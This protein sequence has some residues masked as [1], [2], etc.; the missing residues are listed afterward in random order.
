ML[1]LALTTL[2]LSLLTLLTLGETDR[3]E[4]IERSPLFKADRIKAPLLVIHGAIDPR[5]EIFSMTD[6]PQGLLFR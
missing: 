2:L 5:I 1:R 4:M 3:E 6:S